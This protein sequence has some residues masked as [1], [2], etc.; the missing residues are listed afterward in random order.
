VETKLKMAEM[1]QFN[2]DRLCPKC[3]SE[4]VYQMVSRSGWQPVQ[5]MQDCLFCRPLFV[6]LRFHCNDCGVFWNWRAAL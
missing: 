3:R 4:K 6:G 1:R 5:G 2:Q